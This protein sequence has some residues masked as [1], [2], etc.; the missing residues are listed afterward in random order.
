MTFINTDG[1]ALMGPGSEW[2]WTAVSGLVLSVTFY[3]EPLVAF[4]SRIG[5]RSS[6]RVLRAPEVS[7]DRLHVAGVARSFAGLAAVVPAEQRRRS[8]EVGPRQGSVAVGGVRADS[9]ILAIPDDDERRLTGDRTEPGWRPIALENVRP[10]GNRQRAFGTRANLRL[11]AHAV[12]AAGELVRV[13]RAVPDD[14]R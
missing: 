13:I 9:E 10:G 11:A 8:F 3:C 4:P 14:G 1:M 6:C 12:D 2:F 5:A 7:E